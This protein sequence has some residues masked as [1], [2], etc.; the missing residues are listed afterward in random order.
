MDLEAELKALGLTE[1]D[2]SGFIAAVDEDVA[3]VLDGGGD[4]GA[5]IRKRAPNMPQDEVRRLSEGVGQIV[6][7]VE[8]SYATAASAYIYTQA[9][10]PNASV[11]LY[12]T[13]AGTPCTA[14]TAYELFPRNDRTLATTPFQF[15]KQMMLERMVCDVSDV[16]AKF[17]IVGNS[18]GFEDD[19]VFSFRYDTSLVSMCY[20]VPIAETPWASLAKKRPE[21][22][23]AFTARVYFDGT[24]GTTSY[25][26]GLTLFYQEES[27]Q[28]WSRLFKGSRDVN[29]MQRLARAMARQARMQRPSKTGSIWLR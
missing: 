2:V 16:A 8:Q 3:D 28:G 10:R 7:R 4:V 21:Q 6:G 24:A 26:G 19:K 29:S 9:S 14:N 20:H 15:D 12:A 13:S 1:G 23:V 11:T 27:C 17:H 25:F 5:L 22:R 18:T